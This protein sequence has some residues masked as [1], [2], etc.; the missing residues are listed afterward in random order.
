MISSMLLQG[1]FRHSELFSTM[2]YDIYIDLPT[3]NI[4]DAYTYS[5]DEN[6]EVGTL[7]KVK[8]GPSDKFGII[9]RKINSSNISISKIKPVTKILSNGSIIHV[10]T[11]AYAKWISH[12]YCTSLGEVLFSILPS[13]TILK[14]ISKPVGYT[15]IKHESVEFVTA[16]FAQRMT[17]YAQILRENISKQYQ[18][19]IIFPN[20][21][22]VDIARRYFCELLGSENVCELSDR[23]KA[24]ETARNT[25]WMQSGK[26]KVAIGTRKTFFAPTDNLATIII[27]QPTNYAYYN[28]QKPAYKIYRLALE[29]N[30]QFGT[31]IVFGDNT[32]DLESVLLARRGKLKFVIPE[33]SAKTPLIWQETTARKSV[34]LLES[35]LR[36][37]VVPFLDSIGSDAFGNLSAHN[38]CSNIDTSKIIISSQ[39]NNVILP[40]GRPLTVVATKKILDFP[41]LIFDEILIVGAETWLSLESH[42]ASYDFVSLV[43]RLWSQAREKL[44]IQS[45]SPVPVIEDILG[46]KQGKALGIFMS[47]RKSFHLP[48]YTLEIT[49]RTK[50]PE[51]LIKILPAE[52]KTT[53]NSD[54]TITAY[55]K[56]EL[57][58]PKNIDDIYHLSQKIHINKPK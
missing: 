9:A 16:S 56:P 27:D 39:E 1:Q 6:L 12:Y 33:K 8:F 7:V 11:L 46:S 14:K 34:A 57:W 5:S 58:P 55:V 3:K 43:W 36:L 47:S 50:N 23:L 26:I 30:K 42:D 13:H 28:D 21:R 24:Q 54:G 45:T 31:E 37:I 2:L 51:D 29:L 35:K 32:P 15:K 19:I 53:T 38:I 48:P 22:Q 10:R 18:S 44:I 49:L 52:S 41:E 25:N 4:F 40:K 20:Y 17:Y